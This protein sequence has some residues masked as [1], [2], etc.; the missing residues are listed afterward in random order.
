MKPKTNL[1]E[2]FDWWWQNKDFTSDAV[3]L[4]AKYGTDRP[5]GTPWKNCLERI[6]WNYELARRSDIKGGLPSFFTL[7]TQ[8]RIFIASLWSN[9]SD[10]PSRDA[11]DPERTQ[12]QGWTPVNP[13]LQW[14]L[15]F[16][17]EALRTTFTG[18]IAHYR[19]QQGIQVSPR[20][21]GKKNRGV[22]WKWIELLD[23][24]S[25]KIRILSDSERKSLSEARNQATKNAKQFLTSLGAYRKCESRQLTVESALWPRILIPD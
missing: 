8:E 12:E 7:S 9:E 15:R 11:T 24:S 13:V 25:H 3:T 20:N 18:Y 5:W 14:N 6:A 23:V 1:A 10:F 16:S 21:K 2:R 19:K 17:D 22:S 4:R